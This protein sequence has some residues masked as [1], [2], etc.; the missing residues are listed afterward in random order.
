[1]RSCYG[2]LGATGRRQGLEKMGKMIDD[3]DK[4]AVSPFHKHSIEGINPLGNRKDVL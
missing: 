3:S 2:L 4:V 1:M